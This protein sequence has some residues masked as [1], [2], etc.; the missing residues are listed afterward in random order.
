MTHEAPPS[1]W[2]R[3]DAESTAKAL[4]S[5]AAAP[6]RPTFPLILASVTVAVLAM[7]VDMVARYSQTAFWVAVGSTIV[8]AFGV[9]RLVASLAA[10]FKRT[11]AATLLPT[12]G[13]AFV[14]VAVQALVLA[15]VD[16]YGD[17]VRD[18]GGL[19]DTTEPA[20]WIASGVVLGAVPA[21]AVSI[22]L[23]LAARAV[24][25]LTGHD[26]SEGFAV[27]F[28]G[29]AGLFAAFGLVVVDA[30]EA[31]PLVVACAAAF[32]ALIVA[33]V[34]DGARLRFLRQ[35]WSGA[36]G[37]FEVVPAAR[38]A[39]DPSLAPLVAK[40]GTGAVLVK[41]DRRPGSYRGAAAEPIALVAGTEEATTS[42]LR[43]RR[44]AAAMMI[45]AM[46]LL[47]TIATLAH[48]SGA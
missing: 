33:F 22:F 12:I 9:G 23:V 26:A 11:A 37:A 28:T 30:R 36:D 43:R 5:T 25:K 40:A 14:G 48:A 19:V 32:V 44:T 47:S 35:A 18:L 3:P 20:S 42:P 17:P 31:A 34:V 41:V 16:P 38:F 8:L 13:G 21:L 27:A 46:L 1:P 6:P 15:D 39:A 24:K 7:H 10:G 29:A 2:V 4:T 45:V